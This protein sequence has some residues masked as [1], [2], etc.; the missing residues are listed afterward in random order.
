MSR[1]DFRPFV[2]LPGQSRISGPTPRAHT[3]VRLQ[4]PRAGDLFGTWA[5]LAE[6][7]FKGIT[8]DG[9]VRPGLFSLEPGDAPTDAML[10][11]VDALL[12]QLSPDLRARMTFP[13]DSRIWQQWQN[14]ENY[15]EDYGLRLDEV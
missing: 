9:T 3:A 14:T 12:R 4:S 13:V 1:A 6:A 11:A 2:P 8:T 5:K 7:P 15:V 10:T